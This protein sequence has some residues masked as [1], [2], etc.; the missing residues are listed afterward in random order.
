[1]EIFLFIRGLEV[2]WEKI[3]ANWSDKKMK[4]KLNWDKEL[5]QRWANERDLSK[6][7]GIPFG[8]NLEVKEVNE[9]LVE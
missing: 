2:D 7:L 9:F 8:L 5:K 1:L 3:G 6:L 4:E